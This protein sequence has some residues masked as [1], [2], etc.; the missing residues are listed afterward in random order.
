MKQLSKKI[1]TF[2]LSAMML[3]V[4][5]PTSAFAA[6]G[7]DGQQTQKSNAT[8]IGKYYEPDADDE[9]KLADE[10]TLDNAQFRNYAGDKVQVNKEIKPA[11]TEN[12]FDITLTVKTKEQIEEQAAA[13]PAAAV[14]VIDCSGSMDKKAGGSKKITSAKNAAKNFIKDF[15]SDKADR[16]VSIVEFS[17]L[18]N[19]NYEE[20][21][22]GAVI[23]Q[24][25]IK[26]DNTT[27]ATI[28][29]KIDSLK[30]NGGTNMEAGMLLARNLL[31]SSIIANIENKNLILIS[32]GKPTYCVNA[33]KED[34]TDTSKTVICENGNNF[35]G[36][37]I[38]DNIKCQYHQKFEVAVN[39][40][41]N[42]VNPDKYAIF[43]G[44]NK[45]LNCQCE[46]K[47]TT[48]SNWL[49][50]CGFETYTTADADKLNSLFKEILSRI[51]VKADAW[52][53]NDPMGSNIK[54]EKWNRDVDKEG[55]N[56]SHNSDTNTVTW[57]IKTAVPK[58]IKSGNETIYTY[59]LSYQVSLNNLAEGIEAETF[60]NANGPTST[61]Y[62]ITTKKD[63]KTILE[64]GIAYF[65]VPTVQGY[66]GNL[67]FKKT[68]EIKNALAGAKFKLSTEGWSATATSD[69]EG[70]VVFEGIPS[71]HTYT[72]TEESGVEGYIKDNTPKTVKVSFG[73]VL[74]NNKDPKDF[75]VVNPEEVVGTTASIP[76]KKI[77][78]ADEGLTPP[79]ITGKYT[80][81]LTGKN[82]A[83]MPSV[84]TLTNPDADGGTVSFGEIEY[85]TAGTYTYEVKETGQVDGVEN[86]PQGTKEVQVVVT[87]ENHELSAT[88]ND[89]KD[90]IFTNTYRPEKVSVVL[91]ASKVLNGMKLPANHFTF[92]V[93]DKDDKVVREAQNAADGS[94]KFEAIEFGAAG[95]YEYTIKEVI[96]EDAKG[97]E[98]DDHV[99]NVTITVSDDSKGKLVADVKTKGSTEFVNTYTLGDARIVGTKELKNGTLEGGEFTFKIEG[100]GPMPTSKITTNTSDGVV[101]FGTIHFTLANLGITDD[102]EDNAKAD[103]NQSEPE[104]LTATSN[105]EGVEGEENTEAPREKEFTYTVKEVS[106]DMDDV[107]YDSSEQSFTIKITDNGEG[108]I[109]AETTPE[110]A[111]L[112]SFENVYK[113]AE[114]VI[115]V[116]K[117]FT[118]SRT[119]LDAWPEYKDATFTFKLEAKGGA[120]LTGED[121]KEI[122][123]E[124]IATKDYSA[125]T[126]GTIEYSETG[127]Y[128]YTI[129]EEA[130]NLN[131]VTYD[132][133]VHNVMVDV[134][135]DEDNALSATVTYDGNSSLT[136]TN[137]LDVKNHA[138]L[139][140]TKHVVNMDNEG[141]AVSGSFY[142]ALFSDENLT[143]RVSD[144][145]EFKFNGTSPV[146]SVSFAVANGRT[147]YV[148]ETD[149]EGNAL[150]GAQTFGEADTYYICFDDPTDYESFIDYPDYATAVIPAKG[151]GQGIEFSNVFDKTHFYV[152]GEITINKEVKDY[153]GDLKEDFN[154]SFYVTAFY[155]ESGQDQKQTVEIKVVNGQG[156]AKI[157]NLPLDTDITLKETD[158]DGDVISS[159]YNPTFKYGDHTGKEI[160]LQATEENH[161]ITV[162]LT[163]QDADTA[164]PVKK[165]WNDEGLAG[166]EGYTRPEIGVQLLGNGGPINGKT[167]TLNKD[168]NW[169]GSFTK[170]PKYNNAGQKIEYTVEEITKIEGFA[171]PEI[172]N[173]DG[174]FEITNTPEKVVDRTTPVTLD[175]LKVDSENNDKTLK[176]AEFTVFKGDVKGE[177]FV[178]GEDGIATVEF[179]E[180]G[181]YTIAETK[182]PYGYDGTTD[183]WDVSVS[184]SGPVITFEDGKY[185]R[186]FTL[187]LAGENTKAITVPNTPKE[188]SIEVTKLLKYNNDED[189]FE[190][191]DATFY[192]ALFSDE[193]RTEIAYGP[194]EL[195]FGG[196][197][198]SS[199]TVTFDGLPVGVTYYVGETDKDGK[200]L[201][202]YTEMEIDGT[203]Y[204]VE[205]GANLEE[206]KDEVTTT[207]EVSEVEFS[208]ILIDIPI[209]FMKQFN[210]TKKVTDAQGN[211]KK[212]TGDFYVTIYK[213]QAHTQKVKTVKISFNNQTMATISVDDLEENVTYYLAE[214]DANGNKLPSNFKFTPTFSATS[215][216]I[217]D[218]SDVNIELVNKEKPNGTDTKTGDD[219]NMM[220]PLMLMLA[221]MAAAGLVIFGRR[222]KQED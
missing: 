53:V 200:L 25:W 171:K 75:T 63:N 208:N 26:A 205:M 47:D 156:S 106:G 180:E 16:M 170:L 31:N 154:G 60:Y 203:K 128:E 164:V 78:K 4:F 68:D 174:V 87:K 96:P 116:G 147:Y 201:G 215:G 23:D 37:G 124:V 86:D 98:Y 222:R 99:A 66:E 206:F 81:E 90:L 213:D 122:D 44:D 111:P 175:V 173:K 6:G 150:S 85:D 46:L 36:D 221:A 67:N 82:N 167:L 159:T 35:I 194:K 179:T 2:V 94:V 126:F 45:K 196:D 10:P 163:N 199:A 177:T 149:A 33:K 54:F 187:S 192:V 188:T 145:K 169:E 13:E 28:D 176:D 207:E 12:L 189:P 219:T 198:P 130:G 14:I 7:N 141:L 153:K 110:S 182:A 79:D 104:Q 136:V 84:K 38:E 50:S 144:I 209:H 216:A 146:E 114:A 152:F 18:D 168:N 30:A 21:R 178:T 76:V 162:S 39:E 15:K 117:A 65:N 58:T 108:G 48:C 160:V 80:F 57:D 70:N 95:E 93:I 195:H 165:I 121:G 148:A 17:G 129:T 140:V 74:V 55:E 186:T 40:I 123:T 214:T 34:I 103:E 89:G 97:I 61:T 172:V 105:E 143:H 211:A 64:P 43:V 197:N 109:I 190:A 9:S 127:T 5:M 181:D 52:I 183:S 155:K 100:D 77:L 135:K 204:S 132:T 191:K 59:D 27:E 166:N 161:D 20:T 92:Q 72:L 42:G 218:Q 107:K 3:V 137:S 134:S 115:G 185:V 157:I 56:F 1:L 41:V 139:K 51:T 32:D 202:D 24:T 220:L 212:Y 151:D 113:P 22:S 184:K 138:E 102:E 119:G 120:P 133:S 19:K 101:D 71:G 142:A 112:F 131:D 73:N 29:S 62:Q 83:P 88:V 91:E 217:T 158:K 11:G 69:G 193:A 125:P 118:D 8:Q 49:H 210:I